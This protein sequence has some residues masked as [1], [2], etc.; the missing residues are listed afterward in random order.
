MQTIHPQFQLELQQQTRSIVELYEF[1]PPEVEDFTPANAALRFANV[2]DTTGQGVTGALVGGYTWNEAFYERRVLSRGDIKRTA[3]KQANSVNVTIAN[4]DYQLSAWLISNPLEGF[5]VQVRQPSITAPNESLILFA[6]RCSKPDEAFPELTLTISQDAGAADAELPPRKFSTVCPLAVDFKGRECRGGKMLSEHTAAY[7]AA[8]DCNGSRQQCSSYGNLEN[9]QGL[10]FVQISGT[11]S[12]QVEEVQRFLFFFQ[13]KKKRTVSAVWSTSSDVQA[14]TPI[15]EI[16]GLVQVEAVPFMTADTGIFV[17]F[18]QI[19]A[20]ADT[21]DVLDVRIRDQEYLPAPHTGTQ[22]I[23]YGL[24]GS[25][26]QPD[27]AQF[28]G[29]GKFSGLTWVEGQVAGADPNSANDKAPTVTA[30]VRGRQFETPDNY[31]QFTEG[32]IDWTDCGPYMVRHYLLT[33]GRLLRSQMDDESVIVAAKKTFEPVIDDTGFQQAIVPRTVNTVDFRTY[34][35]L[36]GFG[37]ATI[38]KILL[39]MAQGKALTGGYGALVDEWRRYVD[40]ADM[41]DFYAPNRKVGRRYTSNWALKEGTTLSDFLHDVLLPSFNGQLIFSAAGKVQ[42]K[43]D[44]PAPHTY[45]TDAVASGTTI[46]VEDVTPWLT[47]LGQ[48]VIVSPH[49]AAAEL[50]RVMAWEY[51][52]VLDNPIQVAVASTGTL[53]LSA[54]DAELTGGTAAMPAQTTITVGGAVSAGSVVQITLDG[55]TVDYTARADDDRDAIAGYLC[56]LVNAEPTLRRYLKASWDA[57]SD[58]I[59]ITSKTGT[60]TLT[61]A[62]TKE[63]AANDEVLVVSMAFGDTANANQ[64]R[65]LTNTFAWPL[66][67][68]SSSYNRFTGSIRSITHDWASVPLERNVIWHQRQIRKTNTL[69]MNLSAVDTA[70]QAARLLR[71]KSGKERYCDWF[72]SFAAPGEALLLDIGDVIAVS[73]YSG[74]GKLAFVPVV[75]E[76]I[77][78]DRNQSARIVARLYRTDIYDDRIAAIDSPILMPVQAVTKFSISAV[79]TTTNK[80]TAAGHGRSVGNVV[81]VTAGVGGVLPAPL[82]E[83]T[84]Y[85]VESVS[86]DDVTLAATEGGAAIDI[87]TAGTAPFYLVVGLAANVDP[88]PDNAAGAGGTSSSG[89]GRVPDPYGFVYDTYGTGGGVVLS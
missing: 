30:I 12:Y 25:Q 35:S 59:L 23:A 55:I 69:E 68:R 85:Y 73:H 82:V 71:I 29:A 1:F 43:V 61:E 42:I 14:D 9:N 4:A 6:G 58:A 20:G 40:L 13:R 54:S 89:L 24:L 44:G 75:I 84:A 3:G 53:T 8:T 27:S 79:N 83:S 77:S 49:T 7:R 46:D 76:D 72:C 50:T 15:P 81:Y 64:S 65:Y 21:D 60:L 48:L 45:L 37:A 74:A 17:R 87:T 39:L 26:G 62:L 56:A 19:L 51:A 70:H 67:S 80:L 18:L 31:G 11:Y 86:G 5:W 88:G 36:R 16:G 78:V 63:H 22:Q 38:D 10:Q 52:D 57:D 41:P 28:P 32:D 34:A 2:G 47:R 66:G 33:L